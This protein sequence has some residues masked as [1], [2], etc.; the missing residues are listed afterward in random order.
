MCESGSGT[1]QGTNQLGAPSTFLEAISSRKKKS[2]YDYD[3]HVLLRK[4]EEE[5]LKNKLAI[6]IHNKSRTFLLRNEIR[7]VKEVNLIQ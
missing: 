2:A 7:S 6:S 1:A 3:E 4:R 5:E